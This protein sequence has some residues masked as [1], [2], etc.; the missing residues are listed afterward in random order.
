MR[1]MILLGALALSAGC[2]AQPG[3]T[4]ATTPVPTTT[5]SV[6]T[7]TTTAPADTGFPVV[8][9]DDRGE[10][11]I[12]S[13]PRRIVS[14]SPTG[15]EMLFAIGAGPR[16]VAVD[17][18]SY[19]PADTPVT[20]LS[21]FQPNLEAVLAFEPDLVVASYDPEGVLSAGLEAVGIPLILFDTAADIASALAQVEVLGAATG[22]LELAQN[23]IEAIEADLEEAVTA[24]AG[25]GEG[26]TFLHDVG[27]GYA[28]SSASFT[29]QIYS[30]FG[31]VNI[32]DLA[33]G[34]EFGFPELSSEYVVDADPEMI[35][36]SFDTPE[37]VASRPGWG[38]ITAIVDGSVVLLDPD[39]SSRWGPR[40]VDFA[41]A[42]ANAL[43]GG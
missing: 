17:S 34:A 10:V 26:V 27:F 19:H 9:E 28:A 32:A 1:R 4:T 42:V 7:T 24:V 16:V 30:L 6:A 15:T 5:T 2:T 36:S 21:A 18:L 41:R 20:D 13:Q 23:L 11:T 22:N 31:M 3:E 43:R 37:E 29:G 25:A 35:F 8:V 38:G 39:V 12:E 40:M 33:P 14:I